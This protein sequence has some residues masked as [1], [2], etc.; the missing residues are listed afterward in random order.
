MFSCVCLCV[1]THSVGSESQV[2]QH[3]RFEPVRA[4]ARSEQRVHRFHAPC[5]TSRQVGT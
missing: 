3:T 1:E 2:V 4:R 5:S